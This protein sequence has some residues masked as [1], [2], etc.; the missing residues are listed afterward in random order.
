MIN[1]SNISYF[2]ANNFI[3]SYVLLNEKKVKLD[4]EGNLKG[5]FEGLD[6]CDGDINDH[7][8][9]PAKPLILQNGACSLSGVAFIDDSSS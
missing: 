5:T 9:N 6:G 1:L 7:Y 2:I 8:A 3:D 4:N